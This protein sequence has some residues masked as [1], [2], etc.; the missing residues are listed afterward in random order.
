MLRVLSFELFQ[1]VPDCKN[2]AE[3]SSPLPGLQPCAPRYEDASHNIDSPLS[4]TSSSFV[5]VCVLLIRIHRHTLNSQLVSPKWRSRRPW[6]CL[7][8]HKTLAIGLPIQ[9]L[10]L[11]R[12]QI[13]AHFVLQLFRNT[14][15]LIALRRM[16]SIDVM[17][18]LHGSD[19][20][21]LALFGVRRHDT[22]L[23]V[24]FSTLHGSEIISVCNQL[25]RLPDVRLVDLLRELHQ[26]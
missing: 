22:L 19:F 14:R 18:F 6:L 26:S 25:S 3:N 17:S 1:H 24:F 5:T 8:L 9:P 21:L 13:C 16:A 23:G 7:G 11:E 4:K 10:H 15:S 12:R 2:G 20:T